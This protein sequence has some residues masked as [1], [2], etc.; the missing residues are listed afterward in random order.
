[1]SPAQIEQRYSRR[2][3]RRLQHAVPAIVVR[4]NNAQPTT[5]VTARGIAVVV[6]DDEAISITL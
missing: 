1:M 4:L 2:P 6:D 3:S 5:L